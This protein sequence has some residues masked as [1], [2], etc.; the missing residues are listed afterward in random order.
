MS[1]GFSGKTAEIP[2][3]RA[4]RVATKPEGPEIARGMFATTNLAEGAARAINATPLDLLDAQAFLIGHH[5]DD[6]VVEHC[7]HDTRAHGVDVDVDVDG[8]LSQLRC[9]PSA[10][11][12]GEPS[13]G[14]NGCTKG[15]R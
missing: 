3:T 10:L 9:L 1:R 14:A 11:L 5:P 6:V 12:D 13:C 7:P 8:V 4:V 15:P 2:D